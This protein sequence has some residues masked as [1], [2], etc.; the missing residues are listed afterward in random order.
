[1]RQTLLMHV[2]RGWVLYKAVV[3]P[4]PRDD[5]QMATRVWHVLANIMSCT[6]AS[7]HHDQASPHDYVDDLQS[8]R[9]RPGLR[10]ELNR[11]MVFAPPVF[12]V[13]YLTWSLQEDS[14]F[15]SWPRSSQ[16]LLAFSL[17]SQLA[18]QERWAVVAIYM[19]DTEDIRRGA[20]RHLAASQGEQLPPPEGS[21]LQGELL[22]HIL[23][24]CSTPYKGEA[25]HCFPGTSIAWKCTTLVG[26]RD[27]GRVHGGAMQMR[28]A[29][30]RVV[31]GYA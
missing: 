2:K 25:R 27:R 19:L 23:P 12:T 13:Q 10:Q 18:T 4:R 29:V 16:T 9:L 3:F 6:P 8:A 26:S 17:V 21:R 11:Q 1:M 7:S 14:L 22:L 31:F 5:C 30:A 15:L 20:A 28:I 24:S